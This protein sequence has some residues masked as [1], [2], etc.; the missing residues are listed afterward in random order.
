AVWAG[1]AVALALVGGVL[2][3]RHNAT[4]R[5]E[6][7]VFAEASWIADQLAKDD[8]SRQALKQPA[9]GDTRAELDAL[10]GSNVLTP[11]IVRVNLFSRSGVVTYSTDHSLI[12][13]R[14]Y[15]LAQVERALGGA[16]DV[17]GVDQLHGGIGANPTVIDSY[18]PVY[19]YFDK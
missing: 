16:T 4:S 2:I 6:H 18:V 8:I 17:H 15:D 13:K 14:P 5:A 1:V 9:W 10:F 11:G 12:G 19:W 3:A 7:D